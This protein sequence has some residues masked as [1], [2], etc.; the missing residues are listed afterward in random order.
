MLSRARVVLSAA[1]I[2]T[3]ILFLLQFPP[4][5]LTSIFGTTLN[6]Q[7]THLRSGLSQSPTSFP[8]YA[9]CSHNL[10]SDL[11]SLQSALP[12]G[13]YANIHSIAR[14][15]FFS[16]CP[17]RDLRRASASF[18]IAATGRTDT[19]RYQY[20]C[21]CIITPSAPFGIN[22]VGRIIGTVYDTA[23]TL[24]ISQEDGNGQSASVGEDCSTS[25]RTVDDILA[26]GQDDFIAKNNL[27]R[28][29]EHVDNEISR[30]AK[31]PDRQR[32]LCPPPQY[33][34]SEASA[35]TSA[36]LAFGAA[37][38][39]F[40]SL[41][42]YPPPSHHRDPAS[43]LEPYKLLATDAGRR[44]SSDSESALPETSSAPAYAPLVPGSSEASSA[45][46]NTVAETKRALPRDTKGE[47]SKDEDA[48]PPPAYSEG[49]SPLQSF[50]YLMAAAG[51]ASSIITQVQ[52]GGPPIN[53]LG[54]EDDRMLS[55]CQSDCKA[56]W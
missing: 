21:C 38:P 17:T 35:S 22:R 31:D 19:H 9:A 8:N 56:D 20:Q 50:T 42:T 44:D 5:A 27:V 28:F 37:P 2:D 18:P 47:S 55:C 24:S 12:A 11:T 48:E 43:V 39:P 25:R 32:Q 36:S 49:F 54:G 6:C 30:A 3:T 52:Q 16:V 29:T 14:S 41:F 34:A 15:I 13:P 46:Q 51:G 33:P 45:Y 23:A 26:A 10:R 1:P 40:S 7:S 4:D 53:T